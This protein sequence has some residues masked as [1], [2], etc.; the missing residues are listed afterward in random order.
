MTA[1]WIAGQLD[2]DQMHPG[3]YL[4]TVAGG[5]VG[6]YAAVIVHL[7]TIAE[8]VF[9]GALVSWL[10]LG[11]NVLYR[12]FFRRQLAPALLPTLAIEVAPPVVAG[13][14]WFAITAGSIG[15]ASRFLAGYAILM[16]LAQLRFIPIY[17]RLSFSVSFWAFT[18][19]YAAVALDA[20]LWLTFARPTGARAWGALVL[21]LISLFIGAVA[22]RTVV[23]ISRRDFLPRPQPVPDE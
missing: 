12:L 4:P 8:V 3:Y 13:F 18:F 1:E 10:A 6:A 22:A 23:A 14:A 16:I 11:S 21:A 7:H 20:V 2:A 5:F 15:L 17:V 9:G 19:S